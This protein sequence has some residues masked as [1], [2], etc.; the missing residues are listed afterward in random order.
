MRRD[1]SISRGRPCDGWV[2]EKLSVRWGM[3]QS[4]NMSPRTI[5]GCEAGSLGSSGSPSTSMLS[6]LR[7]TPL[8]TRET[9]RVRSM[10]NDSNMDVAKLIGSLSLPSGARYLFGLVYQGC[11]R[12][13]SNENRLAGSMFNMPRSSDRVACGSCCH[14]SSE[15]RAFV[16]TYS[17]N[18]ALVSVGL[19]H[20]VFPAS[21]TKSTMPQDHT[22]TRSG[23]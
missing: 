5:S 8:A 4:T 23:R 11:L 15:V 13:S 3:S 12:T 22:S 18:S 16:L 19:S 20:G 6:G 7:V 17:S 1:W 21:K 14:N 9:G 10:C 2:D